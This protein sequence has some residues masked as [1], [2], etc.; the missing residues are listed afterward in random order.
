MKENRAKY[1]DL[2]QKRSLACF[3]GLQT[4]SGKFPEHISIETPNLPQEFISRPPSLAG[5]SKCEICGLR[6]P[7]F[8]LIE[9]RG[10]CTDFWRCF[11]HV[12]WHEMSQLAIFR[13][14]GRSPTHTHSVKRGSRRAGFRPKPVQMA[15]DLVHTGSHL[16]AK[17][18]YMASD[19]PGTKASGDKTRV[20]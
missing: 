16:G 20:E 4:V 9:F 3:R 11:W 19:F 18:V 17:T 15:K 2:R 5:V 10:A 6:I 13:L 8:C 14:F 12:N 1:T 7:I